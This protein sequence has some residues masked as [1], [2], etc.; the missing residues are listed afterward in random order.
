[1]DREKQTGKHQKSEGGLK[2]LK[3]I[4]VVKRELIL[5]FQEKCLSTLLIKIMTW[6]SSWLAMKTMLILCKI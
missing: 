6:E 4:V 2:R 5:P 1:M 3:R